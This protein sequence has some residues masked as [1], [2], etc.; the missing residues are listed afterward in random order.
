MMQ[1][2]LDDRQF[3]IIAGS[4]F[5]SFADDAPALTIDTEFGP[6]AGRIRELKYG[7]RVVYFLPRHGEAVSIPAH[8]VNYRANMKALAHIGTECVIALNTVGSIPAD[9]HPG[10]IAV[11]DQIIDYTWGREHSIYGDSGEVDHIDFTMPF[12]SS[13]RQALVDAARLAEVA[14]HNGGT[15]AVTQGPRLET[16]AEVRR[17]ERDGAAYIGMT[18]MPEASLARELGMEYACL[19]LVVNQAAGKGHMP[20]HADIE[21]STMTARLQAMKI[22]RSFF[23]AVEE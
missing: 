11:P 6:A 18:A 7:D 2:G 5:K 16:A 13:L 12:S 10:Q 17:L 3:A 22:M 8:A 4:G 9:V 20:I 15:Y 23:G 21:A 1:A 19:S 14:V